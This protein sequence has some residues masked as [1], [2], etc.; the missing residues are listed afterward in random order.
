MA[1]QAEELHLDV[2]YTPDQSLI[3][4]VIM[5]TAPAVPAAWSPLR[6]ITLHWRSKLN[7]DRIQRLEGTLDNFESQRSPPPPKPAVQANAA[8]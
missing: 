4:F 3:D 7:E 6:R 1:Q 5:R 2:C 8:Q